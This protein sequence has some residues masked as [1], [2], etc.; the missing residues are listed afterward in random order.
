MYS[1]TVY[2]W[3]LLHSCQPGRWSCC[4]G[5]VSACF[6]YYKYAYRVKTRKIPSINI[7]NFHMRYRRR[8]YPS[9]NNPNTNKTTP[10]SWQQ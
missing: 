6:F 4:L 7:R 10:N 9:N 8:D 3:C 2:R 5:S 1:H